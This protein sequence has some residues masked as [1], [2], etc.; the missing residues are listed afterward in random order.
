MILGIE[1]HYRARWISDDRELNL[2]GFRRAV[3]RAAGQK[4]EF[5]TIQ[6]LLPLGLTTVLR[7]D[8]R[9]TFQLLHARP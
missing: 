3:F 6:S 5:Q 9:L 8:Y 2:A 7:S 1:K 4:Y